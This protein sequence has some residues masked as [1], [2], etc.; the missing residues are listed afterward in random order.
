MDQQDHKTASQ[1]FR[2]HARD[3]LRDNSLF[4]VAE[5]LIVGLIFVADFI[6]VIPISKTPFL[7]LLGWLSL[8]LRGEGWRGVGLR[9]PPSWGRTLFL[10]VV[11]GVAFQFF[12][13][14]LLE[15]FIAL[16]TGQLPDVSL[17]A[18]LVGNV[19]LLLLAILL[20]WTLA[21]FGEELVYRGYLM[22]RVA[23][24]KDRVPAAWIV[25]LVLT[26]ILFGVAHLYQG[27]SGM[28]T[29]GLTGLFY[30]ALYLASGRNLW[31][32]II[33]HGVLDTV[34]FVL[35]FLGRYPGL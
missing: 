18:P 7:L 35:I 23:G 1:S 25:S 33:A 6:G 15:P 32:P 28:I 9:R 17:F 34:G 5:L 14:Y 3:K 10:G 19:N 24:L 22:G 16:L 26:S 31:A 21:A 27:A 29:T 30:G 20:S 11:V 8:W 2:E 13:L 12:S 4:V